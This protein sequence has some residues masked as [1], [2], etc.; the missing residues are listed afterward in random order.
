MGT[1]Y[2]VLDH[3]QIETPIDLLIT[4]GCSGADQLAELWANA[5]GITIKVV[6]AKWNIHGRAAGPIRNMEM[7][8]LKPDLVVAFKGGRGTQDMVNKAK[9]LGIPVK[10]VD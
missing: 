5:R 10:E 8:L 3:I 7:A 2:K 1:L 4:G 6:P 9:E